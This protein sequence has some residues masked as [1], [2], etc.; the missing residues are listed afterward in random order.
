MKLLSAITTL[1]LVI[2]AASQTCP[3]ADEMNEMQLGD[4]TLT[5]K[6]AVVPA[7]SADER[8]ILCGR[9][10]AASEAWLG[11]GIS[12][13][14]EMEGGEGIIG[15]PDDGTVQKY[16]LGTSPRVEAMADDKQ[17]LMSASITQAD[18]KTTMDFAKYLEED[19]E[20]EIVPYGENTF[21]FAVGSG[22]ELGYHAARG[23]F[24]LDFEMSPSPS[25]TSTI[26]VY[27][28]FLL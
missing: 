19:G 18:G 16:Y 8:S 3:S 4:D 13:T 24:N 7:A 21:L 15:L 2:E 10:E 27:R 17:T 9:L 5:F 22:N 1:L 23:D 11:F 25:S 20:L 14:G 26:G 12:P 28:T 6:Y